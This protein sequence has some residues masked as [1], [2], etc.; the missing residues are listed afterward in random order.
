MPS[1]RT[2]ATRT[3]MYLGNAHFQLEDGELII[4]GDEDSIFLSPQEVLRLYNVMTD[5]HAFIVEAA[6]QQMR[7]KERKRMADSGV[8]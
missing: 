5:Y 2:A 6:R 8:W 3:D 7:S 1:G 4:T